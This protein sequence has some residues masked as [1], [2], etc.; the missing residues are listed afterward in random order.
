MP[1]RTAG[2]LSS[3]PGPYLI[4]WNE[5]LHSC[6]VCPAARHPSPAPR[7]CSC[8][9][10]KPSGEAGYGHCHAIGRQ[11][12]EIQAIFACGHKTSPVSNHFW[13]RNDW[14]P[15][16]PLAPLCLPWKAEPQ[17]QPV[18]ERDLSINLKQGDCWRN[19]GVLQDSSAG[20]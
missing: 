4:V 16:R 17:Q 7:N 20:L 3:S 11:R 8:R 12:E 13:C 10:P 2:C 5:Y 1:Q 14:K 6:D 19:R 9:N 18:T 15:L